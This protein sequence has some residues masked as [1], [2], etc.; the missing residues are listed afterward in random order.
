M[1]ALARH[2]Q[3][4]LL[5]FLRA[6]EEVFFTLLLPLFLVAFFGGLN[7]SGQVGNVSYPSF[8]LAGGIGIVVVGAAFENLGVSLARE[9]DDGILK[10]LGG[11]PLRVWTLVAAKVLAAAIIILAQTALM[12]ALSVLCFDADI[13][14]NLLWATM[15]LLVGVLAFAAMGFALAGLLPN[16]DAASAAAHLIVLPMQFLCD[17][18]FPI[19]HMPRLLKTI[20]QALPLTYFVDALRGALITGQ[21]F[22]SYAKDGL[23]LLGC[24][25]VSFAIAVRT[26]RWE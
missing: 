17:T 4:E 24:L 23:I 16:T 21:G 19:E 14:G 1:R 22:G 3:A 9:R 12:I 25:V 13:T 8:L 11:T 15:V 18:L 20:A 10:R 2:V 26:F 6:K 5:L 7:R